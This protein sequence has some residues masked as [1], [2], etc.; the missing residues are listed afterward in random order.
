MLTA[1]VLRLDTNIGLYWNELKPFKWYICTVLHSPKLKYILISEIFCLHAYQEFSRW[2]SCECNTKPS[3]HQNTGCQVAWQRGGIVAMV[4]LLADDWH[5]DLVREPS[6]AWVRSREC[7]TNNS[8]LQTSTQFCDAFSRESV[9]YIY[10][11]PNSLLICLIVVSECTQ[12]YRLPYCKSYAIKRILFR[13]LD[14][15]NQ[16]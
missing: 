5:V 8:S 15:Y 11:Y 9:L 14:F 13:F 3:C 12:T 2:P 6:V 7:S 4:A 10:K 16:H 1:S